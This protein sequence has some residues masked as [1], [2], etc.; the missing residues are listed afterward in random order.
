M[1]QNHKKILPVKC[2]KNVQKVSIKVTDTGCG[3]EK[4]RSRKVFDSFYTTKGEDSTG[5]GLSIY[6][7]IVDSHDGSITV[8][9]RKN[10]GTQFNVFCLFN[11]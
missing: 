2:R 4:Y 9:S 8:N 3:I 7:K 6:K 1:L 11:H 5:L 10:F